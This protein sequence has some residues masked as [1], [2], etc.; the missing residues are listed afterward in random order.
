MAN[1]GEKRF[2]RVLLFCKIHAWSQW[3]LHRLSLP[4]KWV[5]VGPHIEE[6][7]ATEREREGTNPGDIR[8]PSIYAVMPGTLKHAV[9]RISKSAFTF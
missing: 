6:N 4:Q 9:T 8:A 7:R 3:W 1:G 2:V 5:E